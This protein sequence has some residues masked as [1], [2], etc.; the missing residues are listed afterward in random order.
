MN[1]LDKRI[2]LQV[3]HKEA[4]DWTMA[5]TKMTEDDATLVERQAQQFYEQL[6]AL[7]E[8]YG[9]SEADSQAGSS[10]GTTRSPA[11]EAPEV[12]INGTVYKDYRGLKELG[13]VDANYPEFKLGTKGFWLTK[14]DGSPT[15]FAIDNGLTVDS[16]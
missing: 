1:N 3:A 7:I 9:A 2:L 6:V 16:K 13:A 15:K 5:S 8:K 12:E 10:E 14:K 4:V 11:Q